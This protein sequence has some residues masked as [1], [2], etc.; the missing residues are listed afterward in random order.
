MANAADLFL[1][2]SPVGRALCVSRP[3]VAVPAAGMS[4]LPPL[5]R[6]M[7]RLLVAADGVYVEAMSNVIHGCLCISRHTATLP[8]GRA[9]PFWHAVGGAVPHQLMAVVMERAMRASPN[10][11]AGLIVFEDGRHRL[12]EV[13]IESVG[14]SHIRYRYD[15]DPSNVLFDIHTHGGGKAFF[16]RTD[17]EDDL[18]M[19]SAAFT[20]MVIGDLVAGAVP[21][22]VVRYVMNRWAARHFEEVAIELPW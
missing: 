20:S 5:E 8:F 17:D 19:G 4:D 3:T 2:I 10:E 21:S 16:S 9:A 15:I 13:E 14:P 18:R 1:P 11:W 7:T 12:C 6:G 22:G